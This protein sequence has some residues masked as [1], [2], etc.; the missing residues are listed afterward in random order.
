MRFILLHERAHPK[1]EY[2]QFARVLW[3]SMSLGYHWASGE[4]YAYLSPFACKRMLH[5]IYRIPT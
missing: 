2:L 4:S 5:L 1:T 3:V